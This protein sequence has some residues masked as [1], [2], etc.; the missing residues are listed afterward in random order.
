MMSSFD[1]FIFGIKSNFLFLVVF[2]TEYGLCFFIEKPASIL[3]GVSKSG[4]SRLGNVLSLWSV[5]YW[6]YCMFLPW[7]DF[8]LETV[9]VVNWFL[10]LVLLFYMGFVLDY[11]NRKLLEVCVV[12]PKLILPFRKLVGFIFSTWFLKLI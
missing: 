11:L 4:A 7:C 6:I 5:S 9:Y 10:E 12:S 2:S 8:P 1:G 3:P